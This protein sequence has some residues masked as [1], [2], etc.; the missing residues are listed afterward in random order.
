MKVSSQKVE[1][2]RLDALALAG[3]LEV[4]AIRI[5]DQLARYRI[6]AANRKR[7][8]ERITCLLRM[9]RRLQNAMVAV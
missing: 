3:L 9:Q 5:R 1:I 7:C 8:Q 2:D 4:E 6:D